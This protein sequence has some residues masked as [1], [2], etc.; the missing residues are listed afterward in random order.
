MALTTYNE[1]S[2]PSFL[3][4]TAWKKEST[5]KLVELAVES[6]FTAI[7]TAN[8]LIHYQEALVGEALLALR[9]KGVP[10]ESLFLQTKFTSA[11]G[12]D[13]RT[14]YDRSADLTTQVRQSF[15]SSLEHLHTDVLDSYVLHGPMT[16]RGLTPGDWEVWAAIEELYQAGK[17]RIIGVSNVSSEQLALLLSKAKVKPMVVQNRCFAVM[18]WDHHVRELCREHDLVYQ[19]FSLLTAN[20]EFLGAPAIHAAAER[21]GT[22]IAQVIFKFAMQIGMLPLTGTTNAQHMK[23]DLAVEKLG[24]L[25]NEEMEAILTVGL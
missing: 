25:T 8:Q 18:G 9:K 24:P 5:T 6:G 3:Y 10:R 11:G 15:Q 22:G 21:L 1:V 16:R 12:Q 17:T 23:E 14:P 2:L 13:H 4:G 19:G 7:D 20:Q